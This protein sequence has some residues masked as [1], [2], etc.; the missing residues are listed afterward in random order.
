MTTS[1]LLAAAVLSVFTSHVQDPEVATG[2]QWFEG[3]FMSAAGKAR[4]ENRLV[5]VYFWAEGSAFC[6]GFFEST[7]SDSSVVSALGDEVCFSANVANASSSRL[8]RR[9]PI[10][11]L[12]TVLLIG[13]TGEAEDAIVGVVTPTEFLDQLARIRSG[14]DTVSDLRARSAAAPDDF[15]LRLQ[16]SVKLGY[17][18]AKDASLAVLQSI[19]DDDP[20]GRTLVGARLAFWDVRDPLNAEFAR[21]G[22]DPT[23]VKLDSM[24]SHVKGIRH[25][26]VRFEAWQWLSGVEAARG[27]RVRVRR[28]LKASWA[29]VPEAQVPSWGPDIVMNF[30]DMREELSVAERKLTLDV[31]R[32][33]LTAVLAAKAALE[34]SQGTTPPAGGGPPAGEDEELDPEARARA[35]MA[36][37]LFLNKKRSQAK[38]EAGRALEIAP[39]NI[40]LRQTL[41][42]IVGPAK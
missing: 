27:D 6:D 23:Q 33:A 7:L 29:E 26:L 16:L 42:P 8:L 34:E 17:V 41:E 32:K 9:Y 30:W 15:A 3:P 40:D 24:Y 10:S 1:S 14:K 20:E 2:I 5:C 21:Q 19:R 11:V 18:G 4:V 25:P 31:A 38:Q 13:S 37:A 35:A 28:A 12:P 36:C 39:D 22:A